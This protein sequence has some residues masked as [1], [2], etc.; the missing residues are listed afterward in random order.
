MKASEVLIEW[1]KE[2]GADDCAA[3]V[4]AH[5]VEENFPVSGTIMQADLAK[6]VRQAY[7]ITQLTGLHM[8]CNKSCGRNGLKSA[9]SWLETKGL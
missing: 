4:L 8:L 6:R 7:G 2:H 5:S 1:V 9:I 3:N